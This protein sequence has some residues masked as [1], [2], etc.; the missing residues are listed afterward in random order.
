MSE[1]VLKVVEES[2]K[3]EQILQLLDEHLADLDKK[4]LAVQE[5]L[6]SK[7]KGIEE[8]INE[9]KEVLLKKVNSTAEKEEAKLLRNIKDIEESCKDGTNKDALHETVLDGMACLKSVLSYNVVETTKTERVRPYELFTVKITCDSS[10]N[11]GSSCDGI[12]GTAKPQS[13]YVANTTPESICAELWKAIDKQ[14]ELRVKI[15][16]EVEENCITLLKKVGVLKEMI[17][18]ELENSYKG[19][20]ERIQGDINKV[21]ECSEKAECDEKVKASIM[22]KAEDDVTFCVTL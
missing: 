6:D 4:R 15:A 5:D 20:F 21:R 18:K 3:A 2:K 14:D 13:A 1:T 8:G 10:T 16:N 9:M 12:D 11:G 7:C 17:N 22:R 19:V